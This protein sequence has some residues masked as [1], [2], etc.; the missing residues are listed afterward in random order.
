MRPPTPTLE[1][2][3]PC[4]LAI[5]VAPSS[6]ILSVGDTVRLRVQGGS[7]GGG[8]DTVP[9]P[10]RWR[11]NNAGIATVDSMTGLVRAVGGGTTT[12]IARWVV[13]PNV[14]GAMSLEVR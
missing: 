1:V 10:W 8:P 14:A 7:C 13:D 2:A 3:A 12:I 9:S 5:A 6:A 4:V 11:V